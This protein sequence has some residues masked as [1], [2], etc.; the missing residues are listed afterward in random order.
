MFALVAII[1]D[2]NLQRI[3]LVSLFIARVLELKILYYVSFLARTCPA[4]LLY[5]DKCSATSTLAYV[6]Q[7]WINHARV[8]EHVFASSRFKVQ[9]NGYLAEAHHIS[10]TYDAD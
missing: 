8:R 2:E 4:P 9:R 10:R 6:A 7:H 5:I 3:I 1:G